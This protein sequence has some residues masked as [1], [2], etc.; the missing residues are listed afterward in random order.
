MRLA[1]RIIEGVKIITNVDQEKQAA[2]LQ[3]AKMIRAGMRVGLG[4]GSTANCFIDALAERK[5]DIVCV[6]TSKAS[7]ERARQRGLHVVV[8]ND[9]PVLDIAVDGAD[10]I[11]P[12]LS[13]IKGG[14]GALLYEKIVA[15][16]A[17][18]MVVIA[19]ESKCV[20]VLGRFPLPIEIVPFGLEA[21]KRKIVS[22][23]QKLGLQGDLK[24]RQSGSI[25]FVT[26]SGHYIL[27]AHLSRIPDPQ[28]VSDALCALP[29]V[30]E[31]GLFL[32]MA[33]LALIAGSGGVR[34]MAAQAGSI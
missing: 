29:G 6:A 31:H 23:C 26:D 18:Q 28:A 30:V 32:N 33:S 20:S 1:R 7:Q 34:E 16:A 22:A 14:G 19:D 9:E 10:E 17:K 13:L 11:G 2:G 3:A 12:G 5:L 27:D 8:L 15:S 25:V 21:T 4:T 24:L